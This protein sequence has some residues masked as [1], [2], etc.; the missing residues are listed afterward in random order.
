MKRKI[1]LTG[2]V[3]LLAAALLQLIADKLSPALY[4]FVTAALPWVCMAVAIA[5][6]AAGWQEEQ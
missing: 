5:C 4:D 1:I 6:F 2:G 3:I